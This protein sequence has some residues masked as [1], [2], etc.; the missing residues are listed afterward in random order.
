MLHLTLDQIDFRPLDETG[1]LD[2]RFV[3]SKSRWNIRSGEACRFLWLD[4][5]VVETVSDYNE[6]PVAGKPGYLSVRLP[7]ALK[8]KV[9]CVESLA[10]EW[11]C[12]HLVGTAVDGILLT[13]IA[14][15]SM[16]RQAREF[17]PPFERSLK[18]FLFFKDET[19]RTASCVAA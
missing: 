7:D 11:I 19:P 2:L 9:E 16:F 15:E 10:L 6:M 12:A 1:P 8:T 4:T 17:P 13:R 5:G 18:T 14:A 3:K